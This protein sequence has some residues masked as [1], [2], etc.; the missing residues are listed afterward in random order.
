VAGSESHRSAPTGE[1]PSTDELCA[2]AM[3]CFAA[4][5]IEAG[6]LRMVAR[7]A[8]VSV[9]FV[10]NR[11]G[12]KGALVEAVNHRLVAILTSATSSATTQVYPAA[13]WGQ[14]ALGLIAEQ[15]DAIDYL[16]HL[17]LTNH[18]TGRAIFDQLMALGTEQCRQARKKTTA[19]G[20]EQESTWDALNPLVLIL[21]TL[22]LRSHI[23]RQL[24]ESLGS[25]DQRRKWESALDFLMDSGSRPR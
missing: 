15:P 17:L 16:G 8:G 18:P 9:G 3:K 25:P 7:I 6:S 23:E 4:N 1:L 13:E 20:L 5:G 24:P 12:S 11:F 2:A 10:Q 22:I 14:R 21:G 19:V